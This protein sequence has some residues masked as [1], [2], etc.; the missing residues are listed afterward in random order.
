MGRLWST[1]A[2]GRGQ[3]K[4][5][6]T[7]SISFATNPNKNQIATIST[8]VGVHGLGH[9]GGNSRRVMVESQDGIGGRRGTGG[10]LMTLDSPMDSGDP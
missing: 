6:N 9:L 7:A 8:Q 10:R 4:L 5:D 2:P 1:C 3:G